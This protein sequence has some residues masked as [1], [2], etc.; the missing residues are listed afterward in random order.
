M[1]KSVRAV[2]VTA[3]L[4]AAVEVRAL[5]CFLCGWILEDVKANGKLTGHPLD[6]NSQPQFPVS[7]KIRHLELEGF[8][9]ELDA[10]PKSC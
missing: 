4:T 8:I 2:E 1:A 7:G 3:E 6:Y 5:L 9:P 10:T